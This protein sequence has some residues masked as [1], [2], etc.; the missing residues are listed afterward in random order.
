MRRGTK[1]LRFSPSR[2]TAS[3]E[4]LRCGTLTWRWSIDGHIHGKRREG[5][6]NDLGEGG[7]AHM[8]RVKDRTGVLP[9]EGG[10]LQRIQSQTGTNNVNAAIKRGRRSGH[11]RKGY[12]EGSP[13]QPLFDIGDHF[14]AENDKSDRF[15]SFFCCSLISTCQIRLMRY[16][17]SQKEFRPMR[18]DFAGTRAFQD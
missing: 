4:Y 8:L 7:Q 5:V 9:P 13:H 3:A 11:P 6:G 2:R 1:C 15:S 18:L 10:A 12:T 16:S 17:T 14:D